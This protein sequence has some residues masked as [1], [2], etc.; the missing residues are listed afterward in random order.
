MAV[1]N[2]LM[3]RKSM[4]TLTDKEDSVGTNDAVLTLSKH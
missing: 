1:R 2:T 3:V 4:T